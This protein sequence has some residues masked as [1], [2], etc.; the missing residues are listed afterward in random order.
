MGIH[1]YAGGDS[2]VNI[3]LSLF[4]RIPTIIWNLKINCDIHD[5]FVMNLIKLLIRELTYSKL[6]DCAGTMR[7]Q[8]LIASCL[9]E[10]AKSRPAMSREEIINTR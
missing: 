8:I 10:L 4:T 1:S 2:V 9:I 5:L 7:R 3:I 6:Y